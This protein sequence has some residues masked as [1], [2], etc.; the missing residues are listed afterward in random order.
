[1]GIRELIES[2]SHDDR[3]RGLCFGAYVMRDGVPQSSEFWLPSEEVVG[4][5][6]D[7]YVSGWDTPYH[8]TAY[9]TPD[10]G[11]VDEAIWT[12]L[13]GLGMLDS[14]SGEATEAKPTDEQT[15]VPTYVPVTD[16]DKT[17]INNLV[18]ELAMARNVSFGTVK[19][20]LMKSDAAR[21]AG[22]SSG[23]DLTYSW[24]AGV[25]KEQLRRWLEV[26]RG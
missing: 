6:C 21:E 16:D 1:M 20:A 11:C 14:P 25:L 24:Q 26:T 18:M 7:V 3:F 2:V 10:E 9:G 15:Y 17:E 12:A 19:G 13:D 8:A 5:W 4:G 23:S 22:L